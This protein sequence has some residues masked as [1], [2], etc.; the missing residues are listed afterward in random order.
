MTAAE[1]NNQSSEAEANA[2]APEQNTEQ[3]TEQTPEQI[4]QEA[5]IA[6]ISELLDGLPPVEDPKKTPEP[7]KA[8]EEKKP[9]EAAKPPE[10]GKK[11][12][13]KTAEV[14]KP[15]E[16]QKP[17]EVKEPGLKDLLKEVLAETKAKPEEKPPEQKPEPPK[18]TPQVPDEIMEALVHDDPAVRKTAMS[19]MIGGAMNRVYTDLRKELV[20]AVAQIRQEVPAIQQQTEESRNAAKKAHDEFYEENPAFAGT[21]KMKQLVATTAIQMAQGMGKEY[22]GFT[23]EFRTALA[24]QIEEMTGGALKAGKPAAKKEE[25]KKDPPKKQFQ[26]GGPPARMNGGAEAQSLSDEIMDV[27]GLN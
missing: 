20:A 19:A 17:P 21:P 24:K 23:P 7:A 4:A 27:I 2:S 3:T 5:Q 15:G 12:E 18:Y 22:K 25:P 9:E 14:P 11:P 10:E 8:G 26:A 6:D 16:E 13:Q 1:Q